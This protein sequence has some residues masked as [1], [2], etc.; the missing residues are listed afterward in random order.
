MKS[1]ELQGFLEEDGI[2][3][4]NEVMAF[5]CN[6]RLAT[7]VKGYAALSK[8]DPSTIVRFAV[9]QWAKEEGYSSTGL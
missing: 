1:Q 5:R 3:P 7:F 6:R 8:V 4:R 2:L 9:A